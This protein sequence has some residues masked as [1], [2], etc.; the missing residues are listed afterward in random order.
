MG[1]TLREMAVDLKEWWRQKREDL[2]LQHRESTAPS[3]LIPSPVEE[4]DAQGTFDDLRAARAKHC[5]DEGVKAGFKAASIACLVTAIP[6]LTAVRTVPW[7]KAHLNYTGQTLVIS[8]ATIATYFIV[9]DQ[10][11]LECTRKTSWDALEKRRS[12]AS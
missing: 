2:A 5:T 1:L 4:K 12:E 9:V 10:T 8:A 3:F 7:V 6:T 11:I